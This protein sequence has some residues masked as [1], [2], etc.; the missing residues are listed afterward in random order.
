MKKVK[1]CDVEHH[2]LDILKI[3]V[4]KIAYSSFNRYNFLRELNLTLPEF[5]ALKELSSKKD[6]VIHK[7]DKGNSVVIVD[8]EDYIKKLQDLVDDPSKFEKVNVKDKKDS[9]MMKEKET[10]DWVLRNLVS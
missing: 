7:S 1:D 5:N 2:E 10:V 6:I 4:K 8:R 3:E 9:F